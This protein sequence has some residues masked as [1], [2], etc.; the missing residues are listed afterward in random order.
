MVGHH[1]L[2]KQSE[3]DEP[4]AFGDV[5]VAE[6]LMLVQLAQEVARSLNRAGD[7][8]REKHHIERIIT[9]VSFR[10]LVAAIHLDHI[11]HALERVER[12]TDGEDDVHRSAHIQPQLLAKPHEI[13]VNEA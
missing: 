7:Q 4:H 1:H 8:L 13:V 11:T 3:Q 10:L 9:E 12:Q 6:I 2:D 5:L